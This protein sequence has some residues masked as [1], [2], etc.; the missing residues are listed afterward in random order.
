MF[1]N[2]A[3]PSSSPV[4]LSEAKNLRG[5]LRVNSARELALEISEVRHS[6]LHSE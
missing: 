6:S 1:M 4:I 3:I 2:A 5:W